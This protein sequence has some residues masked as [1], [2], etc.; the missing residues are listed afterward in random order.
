MIEKINEMLKEI[1]SDFRTEDGKTL[2]MHTGY[3]T[4]LTKTFKNIN[5][6]YNFVCEKYEQVINRRRSINNE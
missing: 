5:D 2:I 6:M 3:K 1:G 4:F